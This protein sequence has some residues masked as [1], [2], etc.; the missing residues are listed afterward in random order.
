[1]SLFSYTSCYIANPLQLPWRSRPD[2]PW[3]S[4]PKKTSR[5]KLDLASDQTL[6][7][8][9]EQHEAATEQNKGVGLETPTTQASEPAIQSTPKQAAPANQAKS[10]TTPNTRSR[11][12]TAKSATPTKPVAPPA[13]AVP[14]TVTKT[15]PQPAA[16]ETAKPAT[17]DK[18][19]SVEKTESQADAPE[20]QSTEEKPAPAP[21]PTSWANLFAKREQQAAAANGA[22]PPSSVS[23][24]APNGNSTMTSAFSKN[25]SSV[26]EAI[27]AYKVNSGGKASYIEPRGLINTG[28]MCYMNSVSPSEYPNAEIY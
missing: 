20:T 4:K 3:V 21:K 22:S 25:T 13:P 5:R 24:D 27:R 12:D 23:G 19:A 10:P 16:G 2:L 11:A 18:D 15:I 28:N 1:M 7:L 14:K 8:P 17:A 6:S 26:A 9:V